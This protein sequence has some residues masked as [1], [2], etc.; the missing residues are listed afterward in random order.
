MPLL[1]MT[2]GRVLVRMLCSLCLA[3]L[4]TSCTGAASA[5]PI[6]AGAAKAS[7]NAPSQDKSK[8]PWE[9]I[10]EKVRANWGFT[11]AHPVWLQCLL[12]VAVDKSG[13][14]QQITMVQHSGNEQFDASARNAIIRTDREGGFAPPPSG[15]DCQIDFFFT[16]DGDTQRP[17]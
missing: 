3:L 15:Q 7:E 1:R 14:V 16:M 13:K 11:S 8:T 17:F 5:P 4:L 2:T 6:P 9:Q 12:V 10:P